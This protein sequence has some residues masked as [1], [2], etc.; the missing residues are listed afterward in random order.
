MN[1]T[2]PSLS[3][4]IPSF[5]QARYLVRTLATVAK[6]EYPRLEVIV[7]DGA[8]TDATAKVVEAYGGLVS[9]FVS[10]PDE[11]QLHAL[12][13]ALSMAQGDICYW[14]NAD[15]AVLPGAFRYVGQYFARHP[16]VEMIFAD[17]TAFDEERRKFFM[18][19]TIR[20]MTFWDHFLFYRQMYSECVYWRREITG[21]GLP[22]DHSLRVYTDY[23]FFL[24]L[25]Y[26]RRC[27]WVPRRLGAFRCHGQNQSKRF[28]ERKAAEFELVKER[29]RERLGMS[30][31]EFERRRRRHYLSFLIR[32][33]MFP[34]L[35]SG[36]RYLGRCLSG[37]WWRKRYARFFFDEWL[38][39]PVEVCRRLGPELCRELGLEAVGS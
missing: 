36:V 11:G 8:S 24:P 27:V 35:E 4:L 31:E 16:D 34:K 9:R 39:P 18:A 23:S 3:V 6:Q 21:Q 26:G 30:K 1:E 29:M 12:E 37:D 2:W 19:A 33:R 17:S 32:Q 38:V 13:K 7:V 20:G 14:L 5:N 15:D 22:L 10:E 28:A 25:R